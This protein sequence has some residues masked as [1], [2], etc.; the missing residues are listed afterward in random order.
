[1][2]KHRPDRDIPDVQRQ[3]ARRG[4]GNEIIVIG[5]AGHDARGNARFLLYAW[6]TFLGSA[7]A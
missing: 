2:P 6:L 3:S 1:V 4:A 5:T 7:S